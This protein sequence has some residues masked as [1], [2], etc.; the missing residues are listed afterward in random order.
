MIAM[1][2]EEMRKKL[3]AAENSRWPNDDGLFLYLMRRIDTMQANLNARIDRVETN[4]REEI[5]THHHSP[6]S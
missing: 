2:E 3:A 6:H 5:K 4:L 1:T